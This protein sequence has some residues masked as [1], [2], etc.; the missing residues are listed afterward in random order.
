MAMYSTYFGIDSHLRTTTICALTVADGDVAQA[1]GAGGARHA[2]RCAQAGGARHAER[3]AH[4][5]AHEGNPAHE[6]WARMRGPLRLACCL[7]KP[8]SPSP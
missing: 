4:D 3:C 8:T 2:E 1:S 6:E 7:P 5:E